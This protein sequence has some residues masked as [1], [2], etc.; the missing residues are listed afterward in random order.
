LFNRQPSVEQWLAASVNPQLTSSHQER[1]LQI[2][3]AQVAYRNRKDEATKA[4][5]Q[6]VALLEENLEEISN[7]FMNFT[8]SILQAD[9][10]RRDPELIQNLFT[11]TSRITHLAKTAAEEPIEIPKDGQG[12][13]Y[14]RP[15]REKLVPTIGEQP[16]L[17][18]PES[19]PGFNSWATDLM[20]PSSLLSERDIL[21]NGWFGLKPS[22]SHLLPIR[23]A[24]SSTSDGDFAFELVQTTLNL[25]YNSFIEYHNDPASIGM[26][27]CRLALLYH[28]REEI[29]FNLRWFLG[30]GYLASRALCHAIYG[31]DRTLSVQSF[32]T[33]AFSNEAKVFSPFIDAQALVESSN[34]IPQH[35]FMNALDV[36]EYLVS[37]GAVHLDQDI[38]QIRC[39]GLNPAE[40]IENS[41]LEFDETR[42]PIDISA[43][44]Q[45]FSSTV[46]PTEQGMFGISD[47]TPKDTYFASDRSPPQLQTSSVGNGVKNSSCNHLTN[48][49]NSFDFNALLEEPGRISRETE[50][51]APAR[52]QT[53]SVQTRIVS[54][55]RSSLLE[56]LARQSICLGTGPGFPRAS[57]DMAIESAIC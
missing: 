50:Q 56:N 55:C 23:G 15:S 26:K 24:S 19:S 29:L 42:P 31:F 20:A 38:V 39:Q 22:L 36:E 10:I 35:A 25:L 33:I 45:H 12:E 4:L 54:L 47:N 27:I 21:G 2:R 9:A 49:C 28:S 1:R 17:T 34:E 52:P 13:N 7:V 30:P 14:T 57:V 16:R 48:V 11:A 3:R 32:N 51:Q 46:G 18:A 41:V 43:N 53:V 37:K 40:G 44:G 6:R 5:E 8:E